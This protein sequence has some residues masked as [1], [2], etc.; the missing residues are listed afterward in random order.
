VDQRAQ[1]IIFQNELN[2]WKT[3]T[4]QEVSRHTTD[5]IKNNDFLKDVDD[6]DV[7]IRRAAGKRV[8]AD[9]AAGKVTSIAEVKSYL[10]DAA[11][12]YTAKFEKRI[13]DHEQAAVMRHSKAQQP[14]IA[15][16]GGAIPAVQQAPKFKWGTGDMAKSIEQELRALSQK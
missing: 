16:K 6:I 2:H 4:E 3:N 14:A 5:L 7:L 9:T 13:K 8:A 15:P 1:A 12:S 10:E 11:K